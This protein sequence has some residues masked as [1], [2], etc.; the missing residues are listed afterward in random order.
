M[1]YNLIKKNNSLYE[2]EQ[3]NKNLKFLESIFEKKICNNNENIIIENT[4]ETNQKKPL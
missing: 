2:K 4:K 3:K 1:K